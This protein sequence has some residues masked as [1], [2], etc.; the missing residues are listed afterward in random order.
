[1]QKKNIIFLL[2]FLFSCNSLQDAVGENN[3]FII[4]T[5][6]ED[7]E[8]VSL[9]LS[10]LINEYINTPIEENIYNNNWISPIDFNKYMNY[11]NIFIV[12]LNY[13]ADSTIDILNKKFYNTYKED[14]F[15]LSDVYSMGQKII[16]INAHD[17]NHLNNIISMH[18]HW[19]KN[20]INQ[21]IS[22]NI[23]KNLEPELNVD[24]INEIKYKTKNVLFGDVEVLK[25]LPLK[26]SFCS[27]IINV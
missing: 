19:I 23:I 2:C 26:V 21:N 11:K 10:P 15:V 14:I 17:S 25:Y 9:S 24:I 16:S 3:E 7:R 13:P 6:N 8:V 18:A 5:S 1:M 22:N 12:S 27:K 4:I 20:E